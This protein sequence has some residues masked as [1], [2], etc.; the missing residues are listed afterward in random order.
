MGERGMEEAYQTF[1]IQKV[2]SNFTAS[3]FII[4]DPK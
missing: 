3:Y 4:F 1:A 2:V